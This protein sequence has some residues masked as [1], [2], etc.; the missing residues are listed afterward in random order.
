[1]L[2]QE[3]TLLRALWDVPPPGSEQAQRPTSSH[4]YLSFLTLELTRNA[5]LEDSARAKERER[6]GSVKQGALK[7]S[8]DIMAPVQRSLA[9]G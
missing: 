9:L 7:A 4:C 2:L 1:F 8:H 5:G 3:E 6:Y